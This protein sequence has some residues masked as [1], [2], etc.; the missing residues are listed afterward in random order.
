MSIDIVTRLRQY[1]EYAANL[2]LRD[3]IDEAADEIL[4]QRKVIA[5]LER[6]LLEAKEDADLWEAA[7]NNP[8][9]F[10]SEVDSLWANCGRGFREKWCNWRS[11]AKRAGRHTARL[12]DALDKAGLL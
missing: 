1:A 8:E 2:R 4:R 3:L 9:A 10:K 7:E 11:A 6:K 5:D 12:A